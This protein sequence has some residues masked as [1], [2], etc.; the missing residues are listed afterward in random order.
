V[1]VLDSGCAGK[2]SIS[3]KSLRF[4]AHNV[5]SSHNGLMQ[6]LFPLD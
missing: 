1:I 5:M 3:L 4:F 6:P 2:K